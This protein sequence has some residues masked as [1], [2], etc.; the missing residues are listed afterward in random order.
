MV[1]LSVSQTGGLHS[2]IM[3]EELEERAKTKREM[4]TDPG[5]RGERERERERERESALNIARYD[6]PDSK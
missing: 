5:G 6:S 4:L 3:L 2:A 1:S